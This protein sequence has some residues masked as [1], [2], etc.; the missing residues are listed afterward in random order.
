MDFEFN[1]EQKMFREAIRDFAEKDI[2]PLVNDAEEKERFPA[3]LFPHM[4]QLGYLCPKYPAELGGGG[5]GKMGDC[6][7][8]EE[9]ARVCVGISAALIIQ[10]GLAT[11]AMFAHGREE[12]KKKYLMPAITGKK[13]GAFGLTEANAGSDVAAI[14]TTATKSGKGYTLNGSKMFITNGP[15]ADY[16][17]VA[18]YTDKSKGAKG[19]ISL[20]ILDKET[21]GYTFRPMVKVCFRSSET[22]ELSFDNCT[23]PAEN[24]IGEEGRGFPY[25]VETLADGRISHAAR[26]LGLAQAALEASLKYSQERVQFGQPIAKFQATSFKLARMAME[27]EAARW[28]VYHAAWLID[29]GESCLK[30]ASMAKLFASEMAVKAANEAMQ[31]HGGYAFMMDSAIQRYFR[32]S[33]LFTI[34]EGTSE[35]QQMVIAREIGLR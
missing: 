12:Q 9:V 14:Q 35:I 21:P 20:F 13:I 15:I 19:G 2:A 34:T 26:S 33:R 7:L 5:L 16:V 23:V 32:D 27:L 24:L 28:L 6:I 18:A 31:I 8:V 10:S 3:H 1:E 25:I 17:V 22:A 4:G 30:E 29:R 11:A